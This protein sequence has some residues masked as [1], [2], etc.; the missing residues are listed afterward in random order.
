M[1]NFLHS[2]IV[3]KPLFVDIIKKHLLDLIFH[4]CLIV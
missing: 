4:N 1:F 2:L 3:F